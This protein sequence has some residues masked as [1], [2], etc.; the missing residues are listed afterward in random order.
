MRK[1]KNTEEKPQLYEIS[2]T[3]RQMLNY[4]VYEMSASEKLLYF[5]LAFIIGAAVG[6]LFYGGIGKDSY[7]NPTTLTYILNVVIMTVVGLIAAKIFLPIRKQQ[8]INSRKKKLRTQFI[9]LLDYTFT[10]T[11]G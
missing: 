8:I 9:D 6:Y 11:L 5:A 10:F 2:G 4:A 1:N 3:N 7:G